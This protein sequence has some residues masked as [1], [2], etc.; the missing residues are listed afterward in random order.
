MEIQTVPCPACR[1]SP[2][3]VRK[4]WR[5]K[6]EL[7]LVSTCAN[8]EKTQSPGGWG[9]GLQNQD[10][11]YP[12][13]STHLNAL[14]SLKMPPPSGSFHICTFLGSPPTS[15]SEDNK[16]RRPG[17]GC[18]LSK[19]I[20]E[21]LNLGFRAGGFSSEAKQACPQVPGYFQR[22][23]AC[24]YVLCSNAVRRPGQATSPATRTRPSRPT[25][26]PAI[27]VSG[28]PR[29]CGGRPRSPAPVPAAAS[30]PWPSSGCSPVPR[31]ERTAD[32]S[33]AQG[34]RGAP[35][36]R[37][38]AQGAS[39]GSGKAWTTTGHTGAAGPRLPA[40]VAERPGV[41]GQ[42]QAGL[43]IPPH[44]VRHCAREA[45]DTRWIPGLEGF[46]HAAELLSPCV[47]TTEPAF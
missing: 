36:S 11:F 20:C 8:P 14:V 12:F 17:V 32:S 2:G 22:L 26:P 19:E 30:G 3:G 28:L 44:L 41:R 46:P 31:P 40:G 42:P 6:E 4:D 13:N 29:P 34:P 33:T 10:L 43:L 38:G 16:T 23:K 24:L 37:A 27:P 45:G 9:W 47:T 21:Y 5:G 1:Y 15:V 35:R 18:F 25:L 7:I 39:G